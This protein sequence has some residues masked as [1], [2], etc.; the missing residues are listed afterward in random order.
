MQKMVE[1]GTPTEAREFVR[2]FAGGGGGVKGLAV[3][4]ENV[5][6][7]HSASASS[8]P[9]G[10]RAPLS[11]NGQSLLPS[12]CLEGNSEEALKV[13]E[14][15]GRFESLSRFVR[16]DEEGK[17]GWVGGLHS[18]SLLTV[19]E[20]LT[21]GGNLK[22][23]LAGSVEREKERQRLEEVETQTANSGGILDNR[24][25]Q[26]QQQQTSHAVGGGQEWRRDV[27]EAV[28]RLV[29]AVK[30]EAM[31]HRLGFSGSLETSPVSQLTEGDRRRL[32][33]GVELLDEPSVLGVEGLLSDDLGTLE[34]EK[35]CAL[36]R[37]AAKG[38]C[39]VLASCCPRPSFQ[40]L[41]LCHRVILLSE[42]T[43]VFDGHPKSLVSYRQWLRARA[44]L[45]EDQGRQRRSEPQGGQWSPPSFSLPPQKTT[46]ENDGGKP[47]LTPPF[48]QEH[49]VEGLLSDILRL[50]RNNMGGSGGMDRR[51]RGGGAGGGVGL[52]GSSLASGVGDGNVKKGTG[53]MRGP[54]F[55]ALI[56]EV[57]SGRDGDGERG[58]VGGSVL[59]TAKSGTSDD[60][61]HTVGQSS[62]SSGYPTAVRSSV[63]ITEEGGR[64]EGGGGTQQLGAVPEGGSEEPGKEKE[65]ETGTD[66]LPPPDELWTSEGSLFVRYL[67]G[68]GSGKEREQTREKSGK[69]GGGGGEEEGPQT[70]GE[71]EGEVEGEGGLSADP[72]APVSPSLGLAHSPSGLGVSLGGEGGA[73]PSPKRRPLIPRLQLPPSPLPKKSKEVMEAPP[74]DVADLSI[75]LA[76]L[77]IALSDVRKIR[78][79]PPSFLE[80]VLQLVK[81]ESLVLWRQARRA[82][83]PSSDYS[84]PLVLPVIHFGA[85]I[86]GGLLWLN[87]ARPLSPQGLFPLSGALLFALL[88]VFLLGG[89]SSLLFC[90]VGP[91]VRVCAQEERN[92]SARV[93]ERMT[94]EALV[95]LVLLGVCAA[96]FG[97]P[98][99]FMV[100]LDTCGES[101]AGTFGVLFAFLG[102]LWLCASLGV[103]LGA[104]VGSVCGCVGHAVTTSCVLVCAFSIFSGYSIP[105]DLLSPFSLVLY[106]AS[107]L[108]WILSLLRVALLR[109]VVLDTTNCTET[110]GTLLLQTQSS[111]GSHHP[112]LSPL[113]PDTTLGSDFFS[114]TARTP[115]RLTG[116]R[117][118]LH[119]GL[120][121]HFLSL[122]EGSGSWS[123]NQ[124][125]LSKCYAQGDDWLSSPSVGLSSS[126]TFLGLCAAVPVGECLFF[127]LFACASFRW[128]VNLVK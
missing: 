91:S 105:R 43:V 120:Q 125:A 108:Q 28:S 75:H 35:L 117:S 128:R 112:I 97:I 15:V 89:A 36:L 19:R 71:G 79:R 92:G 102:S 60:S 124:A 58:G 90:C 4:S 114:P 109:G 70:Q 5:T 59:N 106:F 99:F 121:G 103:F 78:F 45:G 68:S 73:S 115:D 118:L 54:A 16:L 123:E 50:R 86:V 49:P 126:G 39:A 13:K 14:T 44:Q 6:R 113:Y 96:I 41:Q 80:R 26:Q 8:A 72:A 116:L 122:R 20:V 77:G 83:R 64:L 56:P 46:T 57:S 42:G 48:W 62:S 82:G 17:E 7:S 12:T 32:Q 53:A 119:W 104:L 52:P 23:G 94:A 1:G 18:S 38:G 9:A 29:R 110:Q 11:A 87:V 47:T 111:T 76:A 66:H 81:R 61:S 67:E 69:M 10:N 27:R 22:L 55:R 25:P 63:P 98:F 21:M 93:S 100:G 24:G 84:Y 40:S 31:I 30:V 65:K 88:V 3:T 34:F 95:R 85:A 33:V 37:G 127:A 101:V 2:L 51:V 107:P 74:K